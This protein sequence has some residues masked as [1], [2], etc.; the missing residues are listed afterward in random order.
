M[1]KSIISSGILVGVILISSCCKLKP[2]PDV[3]LCSDKN[4]TAVIKDDYSQK[5]D[6]D[7]NGNFKKDNWICAT[8]DKAS[9]MQT[10]I[11]HPIV[12]SPDCG[13]IVEGKV[14]Y[15][16]DG[17]TTAIIDYGDGECDS[18]AIKYSY[19]KGKSKGKYSKGCK[20]EMDCSSTTDG[21]K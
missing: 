7:D 16:E 5:E 2:E 18:W 1:N 11:I 6:I 20:F 10:Y 19:G 14:K 3:C 4:E 21:D 13:C 12:V 8:G 15:V 17:E 9:G